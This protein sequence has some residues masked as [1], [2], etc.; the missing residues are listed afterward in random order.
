[1]DKTM[2]R[3]P[4]RHTGSWSSYIDLLEVVGMLF[5]LGYHLSNYSYKFLEDPR[6]ITL[7]QHYLRTVKVCCVP[8]FLLCNGYLLFHH[9]LDLKKH[10]KKTLR[11]AVAGLFW[12]ALTLWVYNRCSG[13]S[14]GSWDFLWDMLTWRGAV[15]HLWYIGQLVVIYLCFPVLKAA[16][17]KDRKLILYVA[18]FL[19]VFTFGNRLINHVYTIYQGL[20]GTPLT[21]AYTYNWFTM[22]HPVPYLPGFTF[23]YFCL[24][25]FLP[26][27]L[28][29][30]E[31]F[32][33]RRVNAV[34][35]TVLG[36]TCAVHTAFFAL[37]GR[38][39]GEYYCPIW[40]GYETVSGF[41]STFCV[42]ILLANYHGIRPGP[43]G[44]LRW[45]SRNTLGVYYS[46]VAVIHIFGAQLMHVGFL[47]NLPGNLLCAAVLMTL[48]TLFTAAVKKVPVLKYLVS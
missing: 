19:A 21:G 40:N 34:T 25:P 22:F 28:H 43:A 12:G 4:L 5:V 11:F 13:V 44:A 46:H 26:D 37:L 36:L 23:V 8:L 3:S 42:L 6:L 15:I 41:V 24:G 10:L 7:V 17:D 14:Y 9:E 20:S 32:S 35:G 16:Y 39:I 45:Y 2:F 18:A 29:K 31:R 1:M 27:L 30:L 47:Y 38:A 48:C 33:R